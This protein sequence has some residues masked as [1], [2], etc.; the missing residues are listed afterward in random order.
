MKYYLLT[1]TETGYACRLIQVTQLQQH[2]DTHSEKLYYDIKKAQEVATPPEFIKFLCEDLL[3]NHQDQHLLVKDAENDPKHC[4]VLYVNDKPNPHPKAQIISADMAPG[5][6]IGLARKDQDN[7]F[8]FHF[9]NESHLLKLQPLQQQAA[10]KKPTSA[11]R[12]RLAAR[13]ALTPTHEQ[14]LPLDLEVRIVPPQQ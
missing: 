12:G 9:W 3:P 13:A 6:I 7:Q 14:Q 8:T 10:V 11:L 4:S 1:P 5:T 2:P